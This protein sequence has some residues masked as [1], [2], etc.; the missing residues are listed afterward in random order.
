MRNT[1]T[2]L[3]PCFALVAS[4][5]TFCHE[6][7]LQGQTRATDTKGLSVFERPFQQ[8][9][10]NALQQ[11]MMLQ[12][13]RGNK[14]KAEEFASAAVQRMPGN[15]L[16][17][18]N[19]ACMQA[20]NGK[21]DRAF[22]ALATAI[23]KG[24]RN[25][26]IMTQDGDL[27]SLRDD[28][29]FEELLQKA[30]APYKPI[31]DFA[32]AKIVN[33]VGN[34]TEENTKWDIRRNVLVSHFEVDKEALKK[35]PVVN[36]HEKV[37]ELLRQWYKE[38]TAAG[39]VG[40][41]Y[42]NHDHDHSNMAYKD[43][44]QLSRIEYGRAAKQ[45]KLTNGLQR[46][47]MFNGATI[48]NSSVANVSGPFW[49]SMP[50]FYM[51]DALSAQQVYN[52]YLGS[53]I[54]FYPE[55]KDY[56]PKPYGDTYPANSPFVITSQGSSYS[57]KP[58]MDAVACTMAAFHPEVKSLLLKRGLLMPTV[59]MIF[60]YCNKNVQSD[61]NY[62]SGVAH[63]VVFN[64][65]N[66]DVEQMIRMAHG[67][68][69]K[70]I[71]PVIQMKVVNEDRGILGRE[72]FHTSPGE[73]L[74]TTPVAIARV[75]RTLKAKKTMVVDASGSR[76]LNSKPLKYEWKVLQGDPKKVSIRPLNEDA[77]VAEITIYYH[78]RQLINGTKMESNR[79]DVGVF[80]HN[81]NYFSAPGFVTSY[82]ID[83]ESRKY[84]EKGNIASIDYDHPT[85]GKNYTDPAITSRKDWKDEYNYNSEG[86]L[87]GWTRVRPGKDPQ[88]FSWNGVLVTKRDKLSRPTD[89]K[90]VSYTVKAVD[91]YPTLEQTV[92]DTAMKFVYESEKDFFGKVE[93]VTP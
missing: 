3:V 4:A 79:I 60:R 57:D 56:D 92:S 33:G 36:G 14:D 64:S 69:T 9:E 81:G 24:F 20:I 58:F 8:A 11:Q 13:R 84:N 39:L 93:P 42:D 65:V 72:Y 54:Y 43:F 70:T 53:H 90:K 85:Y 41:Y 46:F 15:P 35:Q 27:K 40:D 86:K 77:S 83:N 51:I 44:P 52:Q 82:S 67:M 18:Y 25:G 71:P 45:R 78:P 62:L 1:S 50:R 91:Q 17:H 19:L 74:F 23:E 59:Q 61:T 31:T 63:P 29:R 30:K 73:S 21:K 55:H 49:R 80:A 22:K 6:A 38:G 28:K 88:E 76:D 2:F 16:T 26:S 37:G 5:L 32:P 7:K 47:M 68:T 12:A 87:T 48:G 89:G 34:V 75:Y 10:V 66:L